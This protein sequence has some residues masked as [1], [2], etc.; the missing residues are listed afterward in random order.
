MKAQLIPHVSL[1]PPKYSKHFSSPTRCLPFH[2]ILATSP[3]S[4]LASRPYHLKP[5]P[6]AFR[7][8]L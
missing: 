8:A 2:A 5:A 3:S 1:C 6:S 4:I 7:N